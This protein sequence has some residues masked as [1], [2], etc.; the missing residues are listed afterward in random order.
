[1]G[2]AINSEWFTSGQTIYAYVGGNPVSRTDPNGTSW[3][4]VI[5]PAAIIGGGLY[6]YSDCIQKCQQQ[7]SKKDDGEGGSCS[8][9]K[10][11]GTCASR[12]NPFIDLMTT[13]LSTDDAAAAAAQAAG[14][15]AAKGTSK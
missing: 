2:C 1:M 7:M 14:E 10:T 15:A 5:V 6:I 8:P 12:C 13:P 11:L 9:G 3:V 4:T